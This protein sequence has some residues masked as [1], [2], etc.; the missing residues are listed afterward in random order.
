MYEIT[1]RALLRK[2]KLD[3][4]D[5]CQWMDEIESHGSET[6]KKPKSWRRDLE[7]EE[8]IV[9]ASSHIHHSSHLLAHSLT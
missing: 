1:H 8:K 3:E 7:A 5:E 4:F 2:R 9:V 6:V